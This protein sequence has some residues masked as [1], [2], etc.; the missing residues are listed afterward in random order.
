MLNPSFKIALKVITSRLN[1]SKIDWYITGRTNLSLQG[2][3]I[4]PNH[5]GIQIHDYDLEKF[6]EIFKDLKMT[7]P[8][9][10]SNKEGLEFYLYIK[11][12]PVLVCGE[13]SNGTYLS[14]PQNIKLISIDKKN[15]IPCLD[16]ISEKLAYEKL[17]MINRVELIEN[18]LIQ[19]I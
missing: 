8:I 3:N 10:L 1:G 5:I 6:I 17:G 12:I 9:E 19:R 7:Q 2:I 14:V 13:Y 18:F 11:D 15:T 16:L 4:Q